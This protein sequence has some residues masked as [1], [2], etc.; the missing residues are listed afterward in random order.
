[1][2]F[3]RQDTVPVIAETVLPRGIWQTAGLTVRLNAEPTVFVVIASSAVLKPWVQPFN[4]RAQFEKVTRWFPSSSQLS[5]KTS[6]ATV[7]D[8]E[9]TKPNV[10]ISST[11][12]NN[13][14]KNQPQSTR[15]ESSGLRTPITR[16][17]FVPTVTSSQRPAAPSASAPVPQP[18]RKHNGATIPLASTKENASG[19]T[20]RSRGGQEVHVDLAQDSD[21]ENRKAPGSKKDPDKDKDGVE[22]L[23]SELELGREIDNEH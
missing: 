12:P 22:L 20:F 21:D 17:G 5:A 2:P 13:T 16:P 14:N 7:P 18:K 10:D 4:T 23:K 3:L 9:D 6:M 8:M 19:L 1:M 11:Q 15:R